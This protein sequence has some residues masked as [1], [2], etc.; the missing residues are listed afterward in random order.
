MNEALLVILAFLW[1]LMLLPGAIRARR[2]STRATVGGFHRAMEVLRQRPDGR[3]VMVPD[4]ADRIVS[5]PAGSGG[6]PHERVAAARQRGDGSDRAA[7]SREL[8]RRRRRLFVRLG[9]ATA[10]LLVIALIAGGLVWLLFGLSAVALTGYAALLRRWK[11]E[12]D[13]AREVVRD[14]TSVRD[15]RRP[16]PAPSGQPQEHPER[17]P[18]RAVGGGVADYRLHP[19]GA[20]SSGNVRLRSWGG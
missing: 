3:Q 1:A 19:D 13:Q 6:T 12:R 9:V 15:E 8:L 5:R 11:L 14:L 17:R 10:G 16:G 2:S 18:A 7:A 4:D 20:G